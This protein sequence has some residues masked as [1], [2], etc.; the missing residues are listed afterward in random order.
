MT[1]NK[2]FVLNFG[3]KEFDFGMTPKNQLKDIKFKNSSEIMF[4]ETQN[5]CCK[6]IF[7]IKTMHLISYRQYVKSFYEKFHKKVL[8]QILDT[9]IK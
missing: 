3:K 6:T 8:S 7:Y 9:M 5:F 1:Y 2:N 4:L